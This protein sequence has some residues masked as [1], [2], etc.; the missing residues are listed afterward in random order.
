MTEFK[1][2][3]GQPSAN[4]KPD[5]KWMEY[6][7]GIEALLERAAAEGWRLVH[8]ASHT[9]IT[10]SEYTRPTFYCLMSKE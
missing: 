6:E 5:G 4:A 9:P 7:R 10:M 2:L 1:T 3:I 8:T